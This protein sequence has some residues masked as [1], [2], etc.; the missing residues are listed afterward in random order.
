M[1]VIENLKEFLSDREKL[2]KQMVATSETN[3][4]KI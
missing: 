3:G 1:V 2:D 4:K